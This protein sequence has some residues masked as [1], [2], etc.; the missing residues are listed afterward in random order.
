MHAWKAES[1][2]QARTHARTHPPALH[3]QTEGSNVKLTF[4]ASGTGAAAGAW[5]RSGG[6]LVLTGPSSKSRHC[7]LLFFF[8]VSTFLHCI[9]FW[10]L[11]LLFALIVI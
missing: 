2:A 10:F 4:N 11:L 5:C 9:G 7:L 6:A 3:L 8:I 1:Y